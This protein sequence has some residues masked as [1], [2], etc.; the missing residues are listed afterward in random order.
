MV[1]NW[2]VG[3]HP[4][5]STVSS[6]WFFS[7]Y[8]NHHTGIPDPHYFILLSVW[9]LHHISRKSTILDWCLVPFYRVFFQDWSSDAMLIMGSKG[10]WDSFDEQQLRHFDTSKGR[11]P[12]GWIIAIPWENWNLQCNEISVS[13][14][15]PLG[16]GSYI[17]PPIL[18]FINSISIRTAN[19]SM[20]WNIS[21]LVFDD[22][23]SYNPPF[24]S[25]VSQLADVSWNQRITLILDYISL[26]NP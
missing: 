19:S 20:T 25:R 3:N 24:S 8:T 2:L 9:F 15:N 7:R 23:P 16:H 12:G 17:N 21:R 1:S 18:P 10:F 11:P 14:E 5:S 4:K 13:L 22:F 6:W 26:K